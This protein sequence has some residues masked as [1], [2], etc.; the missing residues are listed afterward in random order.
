MSP[1]PPRRP[2]LYAACLSVLLVVGCGGSSHGSRASDVP[3]D[4]MAVMSKPVYEKSAWG[5]RV[6]DLQSGKVIYDYNPDRNFI[7]ASGRKNFS[8]GLTLD[9]L[10]PDYRFRTPVIDAAR[11]IR[12][13]C[14]TAT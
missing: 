6:V 10:G 12:Q 14:S 13:G 7:I 5:L 4:I 1:L 3:D 8:V 9:A 11:S 2:A